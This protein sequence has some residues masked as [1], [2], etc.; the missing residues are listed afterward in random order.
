[1]RY[2]LSTG[3]QTYGPY[4]MTELRAFAAE[5]RVTATSQLC[6]EG[7]TQWTAASSVLQHSSAPPSNSPP[8]APSFPSQPQHPFT[9]VPLV[10]SILVTIF[11]CLPFGITSI[12]Y[13][14]KANSLGAA[15]NIAGATS[16]ASVAKTW[17]IIGAISG[18]VFSIL[19]FIMIAIGSQQ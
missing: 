12:V 19:W 9:P 14:S 6:A 1:M 15:G 7:S 13:A 10:W 17:A 4:E 8:H 3:G 18:V 11:C 5:G 16:A 2:W